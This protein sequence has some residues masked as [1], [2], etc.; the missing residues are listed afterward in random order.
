MSAGAILFLLESH[1]QNALIELSETIKIGYI[2]EASSWDINLNS[3]DFPK[4]YDRKETPEEYL[5]RILLIREKKELGIVPLVRGFPISFGSIAKITE[6]S[7]PEVYRE[8]DTW[9]PHPLY[10]KLCNE[11]AE[12]LKKNDMS[13]KIPSGKANL[14]FDLKYLGEESHGSRIVT[15]YEQSI[16]ETMV[17][18]LSLRP[19]YYRRATLGL[20]VKKGIFGATYQGWEE[21]D[22]KKLD[23]CDEDYKK[24]Y[25]EI[26]N[27]KSGRTMLGRLI[28]SL[29]LFLCRSLKGDDSF[30]RDTNYNWLKPCR[31][32]LQ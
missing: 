14:N 30:N 2:E 25:K 17:D 32:R 6:I 16:I 15:V 7:Q 24:F 18:G 26:E 8:R 3:H 20:P 9:I 19:R 13:V 23:F 22:P 5:K 28:I 1:I 12:K 11:R 27:M 4:N 21:Y 31:L 29:D 10:L